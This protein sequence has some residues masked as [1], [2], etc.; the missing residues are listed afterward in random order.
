MSTE[1]YFY[2]SIRAPLLKN[3]PCKDGEHEYDDRHHRLI[4]FPGHDYFIN[5]CRKC[6]RD[7]PEK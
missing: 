5:Y 1:A 4:G 6:G 7:K 3:P 2:E